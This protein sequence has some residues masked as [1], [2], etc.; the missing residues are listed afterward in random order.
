MKFNFRKLKN[1]LLSLGL[2]ATLLFP[3]G[4]HAFAVPL[5]FAQVSQQLVYAAA[6]FT[7]RRTGA[8]L[9]RYVKTCAA[10]SAV[11][12]RYDDGAEVPLGQVLPLVPMPN[13]DLCV[14]PVKLAALSHRRTP[15]MSAAWRELGYRA[16][17]C[18]ASAL[19]TIGVPSAQSRAWTLRVK[20]G[21]PGEAPDPPDMLDGDPIW[22]FFID[23]PFGFEGI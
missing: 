10:I 2:T 7:D 9:A 15:E 1:S 18:P 14:H 21:G 13:G 19:E 22:S 12:I 11:G 5:T 3:S 17:R 4:L 20:A 23:A 6:E 8:A 16:A